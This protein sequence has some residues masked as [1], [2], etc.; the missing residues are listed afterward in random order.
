M[1]THIS[2]HRNQT[3][4]SG[5]AFL[6]DHW[7]LHVLQ[8]GRCREGDELRLRKGC[9]FLCARFRVRSL[10]LAHVDQFPNIEGDDV[11]VGPGYDPSL[12][13]VRC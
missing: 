10:T 7:A 12:L 4:Q 2:G 1:P 3:R 9:V 6:T 5:T 13:P 11:D 8:A